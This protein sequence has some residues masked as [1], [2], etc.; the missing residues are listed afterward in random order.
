MSD[1]MTADP[2]DPV[3]ASAQLGHRLEQHRSELAAHCRRLLGSGSEVDDAVQETLVRAWRS[4]DR[5]EGRSSLRTW[6]YRIA[7]NVCLDMLQ[8]T[9]RRA[10]PADP[11]AWT[12]AGTATGGGGEGTAVL[13]THP[14][15]AADDPLD[16]A[17]AHESVRLALGA[18]LLHLPPRQRSVLLLCEVLRWTAAEVADL[19]GTTVAS[20]NSALQR[21]RA[22]LAAAQPSADRSGPMDDAQRALLRRFAAAFEHYDI[23]SL[24]TLA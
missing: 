2:V 14:S 5:F 13:C 3:L 17:V 22:N 19:L 20:V 18:A 24:V 8:A 11:A 21:A 10:R 16:R 9:Q 4:F 6:L 12:A 7:T 1:L 15:P 23:E